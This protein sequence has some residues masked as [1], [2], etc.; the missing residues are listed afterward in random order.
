MNSK[1]K[2][3]MGNT[4]KLKISYLGR[5]ITKVTSKLNNIRY[6][7]DCVTGNSKNTNHDWV[8]IQAIKNGTNIAKGKAVTSNGTLNVSKGAGR[9]E[10]IVDGG[11]D[12]TQYVQYTR[13]NDEICITVDLG[14]NNDLDEIAVWHYY[15]DNRVYYDNITSVSSDNTNWTEVMNETMEETFLGKR[16]NAYDSVINGYIQRGLL[17]WFDGIRN[18]GTTR[19][20]NVTTWKDLSGNDK[21]GTLIGG[22]EWKNNSLQLDGSDDGVSLEN[23]LTNLFKSS[24]SVQ[25][26]LERSENNARDILLG[27]YNASNSINY[28]V[29]TN[30][31]YRIW[32]NSGAYNNSASASLYNQAYSVTFNLDRSNNLFQ[33]LHNHLKVFNNTFYKTEFSSSEFGS[34]NNSFNSAYLGRDSRTGTNS[35]KGKIYSFRVYNRLLSDDE[36]YHNYTVDKERFGI[37]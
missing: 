9:A 12:T 11:I 21:N 3:N 18:T 22:P 28:E 26:V 1:V 30:N 20:T 6:I 35:L 8:E 37:D 14:T 5:T 33:E 15:S 16:S 24:N 31:E 29:N 36:I 34:F 19:D 17:L 7:K 10:A 4:E 23:N 32:F 2:N 25:L 27:N 13:S